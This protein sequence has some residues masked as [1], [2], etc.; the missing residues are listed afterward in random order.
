MCLSIASIEQQCGRLRSL[1]SSLKVVI[2]AGE[3]LGRDHTSEAYGSM[4]F[5]TAELEQ[6]VNAFEA[7]LVRCHQDKAA[8][9]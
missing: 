1:I 3:E 7:D 6:Q 9:D 2:A 5:L 8:N 4:H